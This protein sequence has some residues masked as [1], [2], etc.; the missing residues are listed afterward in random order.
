MRL[1]ARGIVTNMCAIKFTIPGEPHALQRARHGKNGVYDTDA[2]KAA[3]DAIALIGRTA[4]CGRNKPL[5]GAVKL[6]CIFV[7]PWPKNA[8]KK[9]RSM[10]NGLYKATRADIDNQLKTIMDGL[11]GIVWK[12]DGQVAAVYAEKV[13]IDG[14]DPQTDVTIEPLWECDRVEVFS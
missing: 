6:S 7:H 11:N 13:H 2:N 14:V 4:M 10:P 8:S 3:K 5:E 1:F 12:D 9:R